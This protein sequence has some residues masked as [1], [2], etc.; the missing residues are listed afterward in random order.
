MTETIK[1][2]AA[3]K[4]NLAQP[5]LDNL[6]AIAE[7][8]GMTPSALASYAIGSYVRQ[9]MQA[10]G[11]VDRIAQAA[12]PAIE[13]AIKTEQLSLLSSPKGKAK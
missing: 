1:R 12:T 4:V 11:L 6:R 2:N 10:I 3:L 8:V 9:Q 5:V 7:A 13:Q